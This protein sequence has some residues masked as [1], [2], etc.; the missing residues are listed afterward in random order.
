MRILI[1][2]A[3]V[4]ALASPALAADWTGGYVGLGVGQSDID[5]P[6]GADGDDTT[7]GVH[8]G[9]DYDFGDWVIGGELE[10]D[11]ADVPLGAATQM[12]SMTR[13]K[14][15]AGYDFG[16]AM[17]YAVA[18]AA[19]ADTSFGDDTGAVYGLGVAYAV[20][21]QFTLSGELLRND[22]NGFANTGGDLTADTFNLRASFRF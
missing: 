12:D 8:A 4:A 6:G 3:A 14:L 11:H 13:L 15:R 9:Y 18:G 16:P 1:T 2:A 22:F 21:D 5:G 17:A 19:R 7:Y 20:N 10:Y